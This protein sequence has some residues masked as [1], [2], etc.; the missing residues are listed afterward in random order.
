VR[1]VAWIRGINVGGHNAVKMAALRAL[2]EASFTDVATY[3]NSGNVVF[4][5]RRAPSSAT[6]EK[7]FAR[8][9]GFAAAIVVRSAPEL[10]DVIAR[11]PFPTD[12]P[13]KLHVLFADKP[14]APPK[15]PP[16]DGPIDR[17]VIDGREAFVHYG[18]GAGRSKLRLDVGVVTARNWS[19]VTAVAALLG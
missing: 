13:K 9:L 8:E 12:E 16:P 14:I 7:A 3:V 4:T 10:A 19:T 1:Y 5:A 15:K 6:L 17:W 2:F 11:V 18:D